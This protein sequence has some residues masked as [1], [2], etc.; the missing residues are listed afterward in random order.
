MDANL[1]IATGYAAAKATANVDETV[2]AD[3]RATT[4]KALHTITVAVTASQAHKTV[5]HEAVADEQGRAASE[6]RKILPK[7]GQ[8]AY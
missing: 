8:A 5:G 4:S 6:R 3:A 7:M 1:F 2:A